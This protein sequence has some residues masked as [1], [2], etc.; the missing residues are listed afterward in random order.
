MAARFF[1]LLINYLSNKEQG[2]GL[3]LPVDYRSTYWKKLDISRILIENYR[4]KKNRVEFQLETE[5]RT[6]VSRINSLSMVHV[7]FGMTLTFVYDFS[8]WIFFTDC[9]NPE[10]T[11]GH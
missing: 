10:E 7:E 5:Q 8:S 3:E 2:D 6:Q 9:C 11:S 1:L 4:R